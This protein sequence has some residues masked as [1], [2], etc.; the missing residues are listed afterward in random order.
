MPGPRREALSGVCRVL[1]CLLRGEGQQ[2]APRLLEFVEALITFHHEFR[3]Q[4][5]EAFWQRVSD[6]MRVLRGQRRPTSDSELLLRELDSSCSA[7]PRASGC[8][9][10][11]GLELLGCW[12]C[13]LAED[14]EAHETH[15]ELLELNRTHWVV[16]LG[17]L[18]LE[19]EV[20]EALVDLGEVQVL[21]RDVGALAEAPKVVEV[22]DPLLGWGVEGRLLLSAA[23]AERN[24][25]CG[26]CEPLSGLRVAL[27]SEASRA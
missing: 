9:K 16:K 19:V 10:G 6:G 7:G 26:S 22:D 8:G 25:F 13:L 15:E 14:G 23:V 18:L 24:T 1:G 2:R 11:A 21:C 4:D 20:A 5:L 12:A 27:R 3:Q 17:P